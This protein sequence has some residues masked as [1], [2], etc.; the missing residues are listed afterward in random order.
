LGSGES[1]PQGIPFHKMQAINRVGS[2]GNA[3]LFPAIA[4]GFD[5]M[6]I[7]TS[8]ERLIGIFPGDT[9]DELDLPPIIECED[10]LKGIPSD[11]Q[12]NDDQ[13]TDASKFKED[14]GLEDKSPGSTGFSD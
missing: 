11:Y 1:L 3:L 7:D 8:L 12:A 5:I 14:N 9:V 10:I 2:T 4:V 6:P 13:T